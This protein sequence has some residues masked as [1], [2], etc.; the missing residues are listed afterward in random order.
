MREAVASVLVRGDRARSAVHRARPAGPL[1]LFCP[2]RPGPAAWV[3][4]GNLGGGL[5]DGDDLA[6]EVTVDA[7]AT[8]VLTTQASTKAYRGET[9]QRTVVRVGEAGAAIV[10]PDP[11]VPFRGARFVQRTAVELAAGGSLVLV[12]TITAGR[13][14]HGERWSAARIDSA[15]E[16]AIAGEPRLIDRMVLD[17]DAAARMQRFDALVTCVVV[18]PR[19]GAA[20]AAA[21]LAGL[22]RPAPGA[23]LVIAGSRF[24]DGA[25]VRIAAARVDLAT[26]AVRALLGEACARLGAVPWQRRW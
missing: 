15:L 2:R 23:P 16:I 13:V 5:V 7:G 9:R 20:A 14:A 19:F 24:A 6:L 1:R 12:D 17:G 4:A 21:L 8:C 22:A 3:V 25:V 10:V 18:G 26:A 11:V